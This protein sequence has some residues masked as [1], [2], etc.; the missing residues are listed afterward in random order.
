MSGVPSKE[1]VKFIVEE[2]ELGERLD[3][4]VAVRIEA[5]SRTVI[6]QLIKDGDILVNN[7]ASKASYRLEEEDTVMVIL[8]EPEPELEVLPQDITLDILYSD[9]DIA[10]INK[11]SGLVVHPGPGNADG[12]MV[13]ALLS[14]WPNLPNAED[15]P[16]RSGIVH[17]LDKDTSGVIIVA[18]NEESRDNLI[19]QFKNRT[20]E[21]H[22]LA[23][24]ER[25][26]D[27]DKGH[28][29]A[30]IARDPRQRKRMAVVRSGKEAI[31]DFEIRE[32]YQDYA[33]LDVHPLTGRTHQIRVHLA[34]IKCP[35]V[36]DKVYGLR[37]QRIKMKRV[38]LHAYSIS[39]DHPRTGERMKIE[40]EMPTSLQKILDKIPR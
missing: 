31:T 9:D 7:L 24:T 3:K 8:P 6:Q 10:V 17:R 34:F 35:I 15:D 28:I 16:T 21:K 30:P 25:I 13:N 32:H 12:T 27:N 38:F 40:A 4:A 26:P 36:G 1:I 39:F 5:L 20:I 29:D 19:D 14:I 33:L 11:P 37:K 2:D 18:L 23:L 22:Y